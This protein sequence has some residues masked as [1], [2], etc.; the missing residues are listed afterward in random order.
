MIEKIKFIPFLLKEFWAI[1]HFEKWSPERIE[2]YQIDAFRKIFESAKKIP[3]YKELY[4]SAGVL[5]VKINSLEDLK[6]LPT[7]DKALC[8]KNGYEDYFIGK[9]IPG[10]I[11]TSTTGSTGKPFRIR[12]PLKIEM[13]PPVKVI[14]AMRQF[15]WTPFDK[16][17]EIY[18]DTTSTHKSFMRKIG[19]LKFISFCNDLELIKE[20][21]EKE[22]PDYLFSV[23]SF[24][25]FMA[26]YLQ[27]VKFN[28]KPKFLLCAGEEIHERHRHRLEKF[29]RAKL[30]NIYG[31]MELPT[32]AYTCPEH[33]HFH[34]FQTTAIVEVINIRM[35]DGNIYGDI[36]ITNLTNDVMPFIRY[37]TG[38]IVKV[39]EDKCGCRRN[40]QIL[41]EIQGRSDDSI[42]TR[43]G[44]ILTLQHFSLKFRDI[45]IIDQF[46]VVYQKRSGEILFYFK[47]R[48][49]TCP[50]EGKELLEKLFQQNFSNYNYKII[51]VD[52]FEI[53]TSG[54]V[55][56]F[57]VVEG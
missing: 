26:D 27:E 49:D 32:I 48:K 54:K 14:H 23:R 6:K 51:I 50:H 46:K 4:E 57:E 38:D 47:L 55:K 21:I 56:V 42:K 43:Y 15:G 12:I 20:K 9:D 37:E 39:Q 33:A 36:A 13:L 52:G 3:F 10:T 45:P 17:L 53:P 5:D 30:L 11:M 24:Y 35:I 2:K 44:K 8:R 28:Y 25:I 29:F 40:S 18:R 34:V 41:G 16:G 31:C 7:I 1:T 19:L 22:K